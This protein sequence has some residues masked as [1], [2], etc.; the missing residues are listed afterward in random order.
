MFADIACSRHSKYR[1]KLPNVSKEDH[2][3][4]RGNG[5]RLQEAF[6]IAGGG[7]R[8]ARSSFYHALHLS[9]ISMS[10]RRHFAR[11]NHRTVGQ[12]SGS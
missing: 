3:L 6:S 10:K 5:I 1:Q 9:S 12:S 4:C 8:L 11:W 7:N 2:S